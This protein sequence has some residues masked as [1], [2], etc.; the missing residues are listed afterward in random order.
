MRVSSIVHV[1][2][3]YHDF[4]DTAG[5]RSH[6]GLIWPACILHLQN[7]VHGMVRSATRCSPAG[8]RSTAYVLNLKLEINKEPDQSPDGA[9][10]GTTTPSTTRKGR[11]GLDLQFVGFRARVRKRSKRREVGAWS[12]QPSNRT[13]P[14]PPALPAGRLC[15]STQL[16]KTAG[17]SR[18]PEKNQRKYPA[19]ASDCSSWSC[20]QPW[21]AQETVKLRNSRSRSGRV[22]PDGT[23]SLHFC[24]SARRG[25][26]WPGPV[27]LGPSPILVLKS[28][29]ATG[30]R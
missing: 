22:D 25:S 23:H 20:A 24:N 26:G 29:E 21:T 14:P 6:R 11:V 2:D 28:P 18:D 10:V 12:Q 15:P 16:Y 1:S 3:A 17:H 7:T 30:G 19:R 5:Q 9:R 8:S 4:P 13:G 27:R